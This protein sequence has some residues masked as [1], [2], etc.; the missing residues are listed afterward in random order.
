MDMSF[1]V[2]V[3]G[4]SNG[5]AKKE[6]RIMRKFKVTISSQ[7]YSTYIVEAED[8]NEAG[9]LALSGEVDYE[10]NEDAYY[11]VDGVEEIHVPVD[12][13]TTEITAPFSG[14]LPS[15]EVKEN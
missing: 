9:D 3:H 15:T 5:E 2:G 12:Q 14:I 4:I 11:E 1:R 13:E 8:E 7:A 10:T 6:C